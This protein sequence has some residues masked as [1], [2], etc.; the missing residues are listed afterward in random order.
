MMRR[1]MRAA[2]VAT[3]VAVALS[4]GDVPTLEEGIAYITPVLLPSP[5]VGVSDQLRDST[6]APAPL[7]VKAYDRGGAEIPG[8]S[9]SYIVVPVTSGVTVDASGFVRGSDTTVAVQIIGRIGSRLQT[10][11]V[12]LPVVPQPDSIARSS[13]ALE[14]TLVALPALK[15]MPVAVTGIYKGARTPVNGIIVRYRV[16]TLYPVRS[17][18]GSAV[19]TNSAGMIPRPDSTA[20]VDTTKGSGA[21]SRNLVVSG[22]G[23]DSVV[24]RVRASSLR[25]VSLRGSPVRFVLRVKK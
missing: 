13:S 6:G 11:P 4:C 2:L 3:V 5:A 10:T 15:T 17:T 12:T 18:T 22:S 25:G 9:V 20:A 1:V 21:S 16:D 24:V 7:K 8:V 14:D 19:L 23:V